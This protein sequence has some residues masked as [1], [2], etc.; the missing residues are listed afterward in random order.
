MLTRCPAAALASSR[1]HS[2]GA[3]DAPGNV[4]LGPA[5]DAKPSGTP[6]CKNAGT[7]VHVGHGIVRSN[8]V[9][10]TAALNNLRSQMLGAGPRA[11]TPRQLTRFVARAAAADTAAPG[12]AVARV[13]NRCLD[14]ADL[15]ADAA[16]VEPL[17][18]NLRCN[19]VLA[20]AAAGTAVRI[21]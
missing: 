10:H 7:N 21:P 16:S 1:V 19:N 4:L 3:D 12:R 9:V 20:D 11:T 6:R 13:L 5:R 8:P 15:P 17:A 18:D 2:A 14:S